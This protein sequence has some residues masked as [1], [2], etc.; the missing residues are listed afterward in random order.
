MSDS[1]TLLDTIDTAQGDKEGEANDL[2]AAAWPSM[3]FAYHASATTGLTWGYYGA[4]VY[5]DGVRTAVANDTVA[6]T[7]NTTNYVE[8]TRAGVV[9]RNVS[10]WSANQLPLYKIVTSGG[11]VSSYEDHRDPTLWQRFFQSYAT[12]AMADANQ[13]L[14]AE[15]ALCEI[16][17]ATGANG[18]ERNVVVPLLKRQ[19]TIV[20]SCT[21][22]GVKVIGASGTGISIG[23]GKTAIVWCNGTN[24]L[25]VTADV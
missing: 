1:T 19:W 11:V 14:T 6:L 4:K 21:G 9:S 7:N 3:Q 24:V 13:T 18:A 20:C 22:F 16:I 10:A 17:E 2:F 23:V 5:I 25:R 8:S 15:K 12:Q